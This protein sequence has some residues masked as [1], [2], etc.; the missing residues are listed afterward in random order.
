MLRLLIHFPIPEIGL[1]MILFTMS[2]GKVIFILLSRSLERQW[3]ERLDFRRQV[4]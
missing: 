4:H 2:A 3:P 1:L